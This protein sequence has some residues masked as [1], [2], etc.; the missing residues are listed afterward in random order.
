MQGGGWNNGDTFKLVG[1]LDNGDVVYIIRKVVPGG[2]EAPGFYDEYYSIT[3]LEYRSLLAKAKANG[4][5]NGAGKNGKPTLEELEA[6]G[7]E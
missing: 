2:H 5:L 3:K 4:F 6:L 1:R 7:R